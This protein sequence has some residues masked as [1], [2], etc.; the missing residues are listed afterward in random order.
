MYFIL[1]LFININYFVDDNKSAIYIIRLPP[2]SC[3]INTN[4]SLVHSLVVTLHNTYYLFH[5]II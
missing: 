4:C 5:W 3:T 1:S 2:F